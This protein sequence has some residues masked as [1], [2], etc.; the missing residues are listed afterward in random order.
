MRSSLVLF[1]VAMLAVPAA[2][3]SCGEGGTGVGSAPPPAGPCPAEADLDKLAGQP[4]TALQTCAYP[5]CEASPC[6]PT[7]RVAYC[8]GAGSKWEVS[9]TIDAGGFAD[10]LPLDTSTPE[11]G[12]A[13][14]AGE[15]GEAGEAGE[16]AA[17]DDVAS[18][19][20]DDVASDAAGDTGPDTTDAD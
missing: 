2:V 17:T 7:T 12:E 14:E 4:C 15:V 6:P 8:P 16:D 19:A 10:A 18:D 9:G 20:I 11:A 1:V 13:G 3:A 5:Q